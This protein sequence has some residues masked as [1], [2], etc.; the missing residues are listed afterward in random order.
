MNDKEKKEYFDTFTENIYELIESG[1]YA[2]FVYHESIEHYGRLPRSLYRYV[3]SKIMILM[4][5]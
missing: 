2:D 4:R 1:N 3:N 5:L